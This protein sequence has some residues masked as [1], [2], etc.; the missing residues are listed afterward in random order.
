MLPATR[1]PHSPESRD[2]LTPEQRSY[3]MSRVRDKNTTP[4][5]RLRK[6]LWAC[7]LR[8][9]LRSKLPGKPDIIFPKARLAVFVDGCF[10]HRC[11]IHGHIPHTNRAYWVPKIRGNV[12]RARRVVREIE[13]MGWCV[14]RFWEHEVNTDLADVVERIATVVRAPTAP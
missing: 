4:E 3:C 12:L 1:Y 6:A 11:P 7:G 10:W 8:Y 9:R 2:V 14:L 13:A 5:L